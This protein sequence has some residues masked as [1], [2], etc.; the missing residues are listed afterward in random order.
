MVVLEGGRL[1]QFFHMYTRWDVESEDCK[2]L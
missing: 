1:T 2:A